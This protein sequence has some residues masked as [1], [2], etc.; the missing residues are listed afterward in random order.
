MEQG[1]EGSVLVRKNFFNQIE[2]PVEDKNGVR[3]EI[4]PYPWDEVAYHILKYISCEGI[5]SVVYSY[6]FRLIHELRFKEKLPLPQR[7]SVP[8]FLLHPVITPPDLQ[9]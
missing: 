6:H 4:P 2:K 1:G 7:P 8:R 3:R 5:L 9:G